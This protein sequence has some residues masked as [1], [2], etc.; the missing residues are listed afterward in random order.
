[1]VEVSHVVSNYVEKKLDFKGTKSD[2]SRVDVTESELSKLLIVFR[3][4]S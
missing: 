3:W 1:M 4:K 2:K